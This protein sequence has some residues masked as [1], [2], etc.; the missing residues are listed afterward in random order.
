MS[1]RPFNIS[2]VSSLLGSSI[3]TDWNLLSNP[4]SF[5]T[6]FLYSSIVV[7]P[8]IC[9]SPLAKQ[10]FKILDA[11]IDPSPVAPAP[12]I[13]CISSIN[14]T[15]LPFLITS[16]I[17]CLI[18]SSNSPLYLAPA[19]KAPISNVYSILPFKV[20]G[21]LPSDISIAKPSA[22]A[23]LPTPGSPIKTGLFFVLLLRI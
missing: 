13:V 16:S 3:N 7:A 22:I 10:G 2:I 21:T 8:I 20:S 14:K 1:L 4:E 18:L 19:S 6:C 12:I 11:S 23:V 9:I 5:S 15:I 17:T